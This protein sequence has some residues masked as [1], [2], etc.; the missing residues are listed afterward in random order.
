[1]ASATEVRGFGIEKRRITA[2]PQWTTFGAFEQFNLTILIRP[3]SRYVEAIKILWNRPWLGRLRVVQKAPL[4]LKT[5]AGNPCIWL[6]R[7]FEV[8]ARCGK[9]SFQNW[10]DSS[11]YYNGDWGRFEEIEAEKRRRHEKWGWEVRLSW[12]YSSSGVAS[13]RVHPSNAH[14]TQPPRPRKP[15]QNF[16]DFSK[17]LEKSKNF[18]YYE[19]Y[20]NYHDYRVIF[21]EL[22][23]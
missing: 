1:M 18:I 11:L 3:C 22:C 4:A 5:G 17:S 21:V 8:L 9:T 20:S 7:L 15:Y 12:S 6:F 10:L 13:R 19:E 2:M 14:T 23:C 16:N